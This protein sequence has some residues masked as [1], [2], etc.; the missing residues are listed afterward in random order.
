MRIR[1]ATA[2]SGKIPTVSITAGRPSAIFASAVARKQSRNDRSIRQH[3]HSKIERSQPSSPRRR[4]FTLDRE[5]RSRW[6]R[7][8]VSA[9]RRPWR[10][11][12]VAR[13]PATGAD[14]GVRSE[15]HGA[16]RMGPRN[17]AVGPGSEFRLRVKKRRGHV[18][19]LRPR[20]YGVN[21]GVAGE[22]W[23][24]PGPRRAP[25]RASKRSRRPAGRRRRR[26][27][28]SPRPAA[29][30]ARFQC[31][32]GRGDSAL[33][34]ASVLR[35]FTARRPDRAAN[36]GGVL[37]VV[38]LLMAKELG[39]GAVGAVAEVVGQSARG[40]SAAGGLH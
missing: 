10:F 19:V 31:R 28:P 4:T 13:S 26:T 32:C 23:P 6:W 7:G 9:W 18:L 25:P 2:R 11:G 24:W 3:R 37:G 27:H 34:F 1:K 17:R 29:G 8:P 36:G 5:C 30:A 35:T 20:G 12:S 38:D 22:R 33:V 16:S 14:R 21:Q 40:V 39:P 15:E